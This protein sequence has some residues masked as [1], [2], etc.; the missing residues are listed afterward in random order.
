MLSNRVGG[1]RGSKSIPFRV[2]L[3]L[4]AAGFAPRVE[5]G[6]PYLRPRPG[7]AAAIV[8]TARTYPTAA[9]GAVNNYGRLGTFYPTPYMQVRGNAP[10]GGG[11][12]P[13]GTF[14][15]TTLS[16][17]GPLSSLR[18][19][20][21]PVMTYSSGYDGRGVV[22]PGTSFSAPN[23][24]GLTPVVNPTHASYYYGFRQSGSPPWWA[25]GMNWIDQN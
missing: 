15:E 20:S 16:L 8:P 4:L 9:V 21:A 13:L 14:G 23:L 18:M 6:S 22:A 11:Y 12:S 24:P 25:N 1:G 3:A 10:A 7:R 19:T 2:G 17:Y 5:A